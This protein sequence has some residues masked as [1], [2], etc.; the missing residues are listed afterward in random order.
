MPP[1]VTYVTVAWSVYMSPVT[2]VHPA[3]AVGRNV[4]PFGRDTRVIPD[5]I[6]FDRVPVS[7]T[8]RG[9]L[10]VRTPAMAPITKLLWLCSH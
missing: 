4:M 6:V 9:D 5:N 10:W 1:I 7:P 8:G 3:K 2:L